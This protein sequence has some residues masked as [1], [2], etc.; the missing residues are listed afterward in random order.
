MKVELSDIKVSFCG[1]S[2]VTLRR[3]ALLGLVNQ[4]ELPIPCAYSKTPM[5]A[6][7]KIDRLVLGSGLDASLADTVKL[8]EPFS[9]NL[10]PAEKDLFDIMSRSA[11]GSYGQMPL[12][13]F[14]KTVIKPPFEKELTKSQ[15]TVLDVMDGIADRLPKGIRGNY[16]A[17]IAQTRNQIRG[18]DV[19]IPFS[20]TGFR[21]KLINDLSVLTR[22]RKFVE[23]VVA[24]SR[25]MPHHTEPGAA[26][27]QM[28]VLDTIENVL[29]KAAARGEIPI[30]G[31]LRR[32]LVASQKRIA[33]EHV[34][35]VFQ[36]KAFINDLRQAL[37]GYRDPA[38][39]YQLAQMLPKAENNP[40]A[41]MVKYCN[42]SPRQLVKK[43]FLHSKGTIEHIY[44]D[45]LGG[46]SSLE[47]LL[48]ASHRYNGFRADTPFFEYV[49]KTPTVL[50]NIDNFIELFSTPQG[51]KLL[52]AK[53]VSLEWPNMLKDTIKN[54]TSSFYKF[55]RSV[56]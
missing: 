24:L 53:G 8:V 43:M 33:G 23:D 34:D 9:A 10:Q 16:D 38:R 31:D 3:R 55:F 1:A 13:G 4:E 25:A 51:Q 17:L 5:I 54:M 56:C 30:S 40:D 35:E 6:E 39:F 45:S 49:T 18:E 2:S 14:M 41:A 42:L 50:E 37:K 27:R 48:L 26:A 36:N 12:T 32:L 52:K 22:D 7:P 28:K 11:Q 19:R 29:H 44:P 46:R 15:E 20:R 21:I 47:N